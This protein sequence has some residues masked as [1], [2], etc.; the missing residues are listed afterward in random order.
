MVYDTS[1]QMAHSAYFK[2]QFVMSGK[3]RRWSSKKRCLPLSALPG[4]SRQTPL[5][6]GHMLPRELMAMALLDP[7]FMRE[8]LLFHAQRTRS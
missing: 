2:L 6:S 3:T 8:L 4:S 1:V 7:A 5:A